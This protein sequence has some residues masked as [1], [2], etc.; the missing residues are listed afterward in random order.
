MAVKV[1]HH[2]GAWWVFIDHKGKRKAKR[3]GNSKKAAEQVAEKIQAKIALGQFEIKDE[4]QRRPFDV[5]F[6]NWLE[7][8]VKAHCKERT[9]DLYA[10]AFR[11]YLLPAFG[12]KDITAITREEV[13]K[14]AYGMLA[15]GKSRSTVNNVLAPMQGMFSQALEDGH[16][17]RNPCFRILK[18]SRKEESE[19]K[20]SFLTREEFGVLLR[21]CREEFS[22]YYPFISLLARTGLRMG[23]ARGLQWSDV[24]FHGRFIAVQRTL[25]HERTSTPKSGKSRRVICPSS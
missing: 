8:Y 14:L 6:R 16:T 5:Y 4:Q 1:K 22:A 21:T 2:K 11:L 18:K 13:K 24:D 20:A 25:S 23:E 19:G 15:Q 10:A 12:Q 7:T 3:I 17:D 9:Y